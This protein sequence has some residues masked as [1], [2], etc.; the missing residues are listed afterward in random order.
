[1]GC[2][3]GGE[4]KLRIVDS[5]GRVAACEWVFATTDLLRDSV[6]FGLPGSK[7]RF[8]FASLAWSCPRYAISD[9]G[10]AAIDAI[11]AMGAMSAMGA[12][13]AMGGVD[14]GARWGVFFCSRY[15]GG[16]SLPVGGFWWWG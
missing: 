6:F 9:G 13:G 16:M 5:C 7:L 15:G 12:M 4:Q 10:L 14:G 2:R 8:G 3:D 11:D 1:M